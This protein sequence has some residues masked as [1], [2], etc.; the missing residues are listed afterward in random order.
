MI[1]KS[2]PSFSVVLPTSLLAD[3]PNLRQKT[4]KVGSVGRTLAIFRIDN[5]CIYND[6]DPSV[7]NQ[8]SEAELISMLLRYMETPQ[9]LRKLLFP[10]KKELRYAGLLPPLRT[11]HH[12]LEDEKNDPG[13]YREA[14]VLEVD[15]RGSLLEIGLREKGFTKERLKTGDRLTVKLDKHLDRSTIGVM[16][17][18]KADVGE[19]WGYDVSRTKS[20]AEGLNRLKAD[21]AIGTSRRGQNLYEAVQAIGSNKPHNVAVVFGGPYAGLLEICD[22][23]G[24]DAGELFD[25][26]VNA[27]P[28]QGTATVRTEEAIVATLALLNVLVRG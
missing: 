10:R 1:S 20:L 7:I 26:L 4:L 9:Y 2:T 12:P 8:T 14:V 19:Y 23:Q 28:E 18:A 6:D 17:A 21:Y 22:R 13:D 15:G 24:V 11:P 16:C 27:I 25:V 3:A 5:V